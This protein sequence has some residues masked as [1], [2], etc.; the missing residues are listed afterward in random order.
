MEED[1]DISDSEH[2]PGD[3]RHVQLT[4]ISKENEYVCVFI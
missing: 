2:F 3:D 1:A 4:F